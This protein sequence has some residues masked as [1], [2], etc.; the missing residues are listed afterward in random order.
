M[1][2]NKIHIKNWKCFVDKT[3]SFD[4]QNI[5]NQPNGKGKTSL[6][7]AI[8]FCLFG[9]RPTGF[10]FTTLRND[11]TS[12]CII[13]INFVYNDKEGVQHDVTVRRQFG[14]TNVVTLKQDGVLVCSS[15]TSVF[16]FMNNILPYDIISVLWAP[17]T[18][19]SS[20]I[21]QPD[22]LIKSLFNYVFRDPQKIEKYYKYEL[23]NTNKKLKSF[24]VP[25]NYKK[26][27]DRLTTVESKINDIRG[28]IK[29]RGSSSNHQ[30]NMA[31]AAEQANKELISMNIT[32]KIPINICFEFRNFV[33]N[34]DVS[35]LKKQIKDDIDREN[36]KTTSILDKLPS[37]IVK[38][39]KDESEKGKCIICDSDWDMSI[40]EKIDKLISQGKI[41]HNKIKNL[42]NK[43]ALLSYNK[44]SVDD[45]IRYNELSSVVSKCPNFKE[46]IKNYDEDNNRLW[47]ELN[48]LEL[49][50]KN[51]LRQK[52]E[53]INYIKEKKKQEEIKNKLSVVQTYI[54]DASEYYSNTMTENGSLILN[55]LSPKFEQV[56][57]DEG[58]YKISKVNY[59]MNSIDLLSA[60]QL[61][62]GE[63]TLVGVSLILAAHSL[64]FPN[65]PLL[66][67]E[68]FSALDKEHISSLKEYFNKSSF[69]LFII[70]HDNYWIE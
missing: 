21:L 23:F 28:R 6:F 27:E 41:D 30:V 8:I 37:N 11:I 50:Q 4:R 51:I 48:S 64:F 55:N 18:L 42:N 63:R 68:S 67:D 1:L 46:I 5:I 61:S 20:S 24:N 2:I 43:L 9:K 52:E 58:E 3:F 45:N 62:S 70:T 19:Q 31:K 14:A 22:F 49:E 7:Q 16:E 65:I 12:D 59:E 34:Q 25:P 33:R 36:S 69:Q 47:D 44:K 60:A 10:N 32:E 17:G 54:S 56:F 15:A 29:K 38:F 26:L 39:I 13:T 40:S 35:L 53:Y 57:L 66:F